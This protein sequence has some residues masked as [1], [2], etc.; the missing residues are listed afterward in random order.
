MR[1]YIFMPEFEHNAQKLPGNIKDLLKDLLLFFKQDPF[2][3]RLHPKPLKD[4]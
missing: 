1:Q 2:H 3:P 4:K